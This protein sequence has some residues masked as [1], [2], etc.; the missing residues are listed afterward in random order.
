M[1]LMT[2]QNLVDLNDICL[3]LLTKKVMKKARLDSCLAELM[4][5]KKVD[6]LFSLQGQLMVIKNA[7]DLVSR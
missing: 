5:L 1:V 6:C 2:E 7:V 3:V 4:V